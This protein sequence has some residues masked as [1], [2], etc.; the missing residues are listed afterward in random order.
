[1]KSKDAIKRVIFVFGKHYYSLD[2]ERTK[3]G[4][5]ATENVAIVRVEEMSPFPASE[6]RDVLKSYKNA[7]EFVWAQEEHRNMGAWS[8]AAP[9]FERILGI[10]LAYAGRENRSAVV[11]IGT[12]HA[13]EVKHVLSKPFEK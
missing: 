5:A 3:R 7:N 6:L 1:M 11:G 8:F 10:R 13:A 12:L 4:A 2:E 9:R